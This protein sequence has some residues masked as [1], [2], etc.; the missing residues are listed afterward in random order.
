MSSYKNH[1]EKVVVQANK[2]N[3][4]IQ[5][6]GYLNTIV[7]WNDTANSTGGTAYSYSFAIFA[8]KFTAYNISFKVIKQACMQFNMLLSLFHFL[9][10]CMVIDIEQ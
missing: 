9:C 1:R 7:E 2:T 3:L 5:G 10:F 6:Q 8:S 4:I